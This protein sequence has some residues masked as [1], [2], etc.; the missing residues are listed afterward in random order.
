MVVCL[1]GSLRQSMPWSSTASLLLQAHAG[2]DESELRNV[3][4]QAVWLVTDGH[5]T[6]DCILHFKAAGCGCSAE[7]STSPLHDSTLSST[8]FASTPRYCIGNVGGRVL[9]LPE[10]SFFSRLE[11][12]ATSSLR[13]PGTF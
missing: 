7:L 3:A 13:D 2:L 6:A 10:N 8:V 1:E 9:K 11:R 4:V 5:L 12:F